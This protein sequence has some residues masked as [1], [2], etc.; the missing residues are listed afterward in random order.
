MI[1]YLDSS[2]HYI[3]ISIPSTYT[4]LNIDKNIYHV[5]IT[6][7]STTSLHIHTIETNNINNKH[8]IKIEINII[9]LY[10]YY[11]YIHYTPIYVQLIFFEF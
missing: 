2:F 11:R 9:Y 10:T 8:V 1:S 5:Y 7:K 6:N 4:L 3:I